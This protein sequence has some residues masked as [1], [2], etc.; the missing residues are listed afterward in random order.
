M[1]TS[2]LNEI[3][4]DTT[5]FD[6]F[7]DNAQMRVEGIRPWVV[8]R[9]QDATQIASPGDDFTVGKTLASDFREWYDEAPIQ[10]V[11]N[12]VSQPLVEV[13]FADRFIYKSSGGRFAADY[14]N[15]LFYLLTNI[16]QAYTIY[17]NYIRVAPLVSANNTWVFPERFHKILPLM[18]AEMWKNGIDYDVVSNAQASQ[19]SM[20]AAAMLSEM[21]RWDSRLQLNMTRGIDS[22]ASMGSFNNGVMNGTNIL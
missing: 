22:T 17:Q 19:Q 4:I 8:L 9:T 16:N 11:S 2:L 12:N 6:T 15:N 7:L 5:L 1:V 13:P 21:T 10:L 14:V 20:Q 3:Q 18:I